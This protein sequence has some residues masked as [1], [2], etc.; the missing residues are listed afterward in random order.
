[1]IVNLNDPRQWQICAA[2]QKGSYICIYYSLAIYS[3]LI[4]KIMGGL[5]LEVNRILTPPTF[6]G[7]TPIHCSEHNGFIPQPYIHPKLTHHLGRQAVTE[8]VRCS[9]FCTDKPSVVQ[10]L[11]LQPFDKDLKN[12]L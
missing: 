6:P 3:Y 5:G 12:S 8:E 2:N 9:L 11:S 4:K 10:F 1:M 7:S